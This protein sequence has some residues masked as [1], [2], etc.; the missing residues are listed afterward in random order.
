VESDGLKM[1]LKLET[2]EGLKR[3]YAEQKDT[4]IYMSKFGNAFERAQAALIISVALEA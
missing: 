3:L 2:I 4:I 1:A